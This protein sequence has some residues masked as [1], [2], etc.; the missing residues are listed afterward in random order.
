MTIKY[1]K[2]ALDLDGVVTNFHQKLIDIYNERFQQ[3]LTVHDIDGDLESLGPELARELIK[4]FN[5]DG[6]I[7]GLEPLPNSV[8]I[9]SQFPDLGY[10]VTICTAPARDLT[11]LI[12]PISAQEKFSWV[13]KWLPFWA[14]DV[15]VTK[16]KELVSTDLLIDDWPPNI[17]NW[18]EKQSGIGILIDQPWNKN[19][20]HFPIN[21]VRA[22]LQDVVPFIE[23]FWCQQR[24]EFIYRMEELEEWQ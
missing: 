6:Y 22:S 21:S 17:V 19:F 16:H 14:N 1:P 3:Q 18:C 7:E 24:G 2:I 9:V 5:E 11:G 4:I 8:Q 10:K 23:K 12:N 15:I 13:A 20:K